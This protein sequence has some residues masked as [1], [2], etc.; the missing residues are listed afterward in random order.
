MKQSCATLNVSPVSL[1]AVTEQHDNQ[2][3]ENTPQVS[4]TPR[5]C[6]DHECPSHTMP[7]YCHEEESLGKETRRNL[8]EKAVHTT[9][10]PR[11]NPAQLHGTHKQLSL[12]SWSLGHVANMLV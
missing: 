5:H 6:Y 11:V 8:S 9:A 12:P 10:E 7:L 1:T 4:I 2:P 3:S